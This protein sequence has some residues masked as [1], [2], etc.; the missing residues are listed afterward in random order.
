MSDVTLLTGAV[1]GLAGAIAMVVVMNARGGD[2]PPPF[3]V[4]WAKFLGGDPAS[5]MPQALS[6]HAVYAV[7]A[8]AVYTVVFN[9]VGDSLGLATTGFTVGIVWGIVYGEVLLV[10]AMLFWGK[11]VLDMDPDSDQLMTLALAHLSYGLVLGV[12]GA[13]IPHLV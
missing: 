8:G 9:P 11:L 12:L 6:L 1:W 5:A 4:F 10:G 7:V 13:A 3:A 2:A